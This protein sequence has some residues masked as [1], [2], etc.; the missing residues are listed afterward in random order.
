MWIPVQVVASFFRKKPDR[1]S[2][3]FDILIPTRGG[4]FIINNKSSAKSFLFEF[5]I[6]YLLYKIHFEF[7]SIQNDPPC[8]FFTKE[9]VIWDK[10]NL[11]DNSF[12]LSWFN[13]LNHLWLQKYKEEKENKLAKLRRHASRVHFAKIL[14]R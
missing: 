10:I 9:N 2:M 3:S 6:N 1:G 13:E 4:W 7:Q 8:S 12:P 11:C 5:S 14:F